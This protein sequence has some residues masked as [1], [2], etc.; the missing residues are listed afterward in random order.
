MDLIPLQP[1]GW[2]LNA[3][4]DLVLYG[5]QSLTRWESMFREYYY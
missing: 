5:L 3:D 1:I 2:E 4:Q